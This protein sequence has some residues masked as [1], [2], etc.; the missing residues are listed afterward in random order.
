M[1]GPTGKPIDRADGRLKVTG[2]A[3][4]SAE[5]MPERITYGVLINSTIARGRIRS[6][7]TR[8]AERV[9]GV[10]AIVTHLNAP[11]LSKLKGFMEGG[12]GAESRIPLQDG[13]ILHGGQPIGVVVADS[14]ERA[15][16][17]AMNVRVSYQTEKPLVEMDEQ[18]ASAFTP[19]PIFGDSP[20]KKH[21]DPD[22][23]LAAAEVKVESTYS[24]PTEHH[25]PMEPHATTAIW[26]GNQLLVYDATQY[27]SGCQQSLATAFAIPPENVRVL[28]PFVG[29]GFGTKA[30]TWPHIVLAALASKVV[31]RPVKLVLTR[32]QMY[33]STGHRS[34]TFQKVALGASRS[35]KLSSIIHESTNYTSMKD[36]FVEPSAGVS[37]MMYASPNRRT[38]HRLVRLNRPIPTFQR[39]PGESVGSFALESAMDE[40]AW[41][42]AMDPIELRNLNDAEVD[43]ESGRPWSSKSLKQCF[44]QGA[45]RFGWSRRGREPRSMRDG[46]A[47]VGMGMASATF[48]AFSFPASARVTVFADG[49]ALAQSG[50]HEMGM[51]TATVMAQLA[52]EYLGIP[53]E[54][55]RFEL[56]DTRLPTAGVSGG[57]ST[58][59]S[60]GTAVKGAADALREKV[61]TLVREDASSPLRGAAAE[62]VGWA[63]GRL[64]L[65]SDPSRG[66]SYSDILRRKY[67]NQIDATYDAKPNWESKYASH[68]FG[69]HFAEVRVDPD[70]GE[71]RVSRWVAAFAAGRILNP[72]T[73]R[74]QFLGG[75]TWG[76]GMALMEQTHMDE[77]LGRFT[78]ANIAE[79]LVPVNLDVPPIE[80]LLVEEHDPHV[81]PIGTKGIGEIGIV[82]AAAA[83]ANA[84][85]HATGKRIR[86]LP[87]TVEKLL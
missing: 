44:A 80:V 22:T 46:R 64:V 76:I 63:D 20:D 61:L 14:F 16:E 49:S 10:I 79:Y 52:S 73:A 2:G 57:S 36:E 56:G 83:I 35:G 82:G 39:A 60:V 55:V 69:A 29:G 7:D 6:I 18:M 27:V 11:K 48:P 12:G 51:G 59:S 37:T 17:A 43:P 75:I 87:I 28:A 78:N 40:L 67:L 1:N 33:F 21:G 9:P 81:N 13:V 24:T 72:K 47:L 26:S 68:A 53:V 65:K 42:L 3:R 86:D 23:A 71:V 30:S 8:A 50:S 70:L 45:D 66:E 4:F 85:Y 19:G 25:N 54:R 41:K 84:V 15:T 62:D 74:S 34:A 32:K 58:A 5:H 38:S 77:N 31:R